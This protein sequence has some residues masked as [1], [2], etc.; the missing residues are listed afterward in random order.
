MAITFK[1][2]KI[3]AQFFFATYSK[4]DRELE[5]TKSKKKNICFQKLYLEGANLH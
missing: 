1:R 3:I 5:N 4:I 2:L